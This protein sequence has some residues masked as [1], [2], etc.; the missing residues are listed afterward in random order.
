MMK[1]HCND[2]VIGKLIY[3]FKEKIVCKIKYSIMLYIV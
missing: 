1:V 2:M 3:S